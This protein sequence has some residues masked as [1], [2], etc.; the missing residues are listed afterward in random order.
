MRVA[1]VGAGI[2]GLTCALRL[3]QQGHRV[4]VFESEPEV[5]GRMGTTRVEGFCV[6]TGANLLL[7]N[8]ARLHA[9][10]DELG[11]A[12]QLFDF[13]SG[14]G[15]ILRDHELT[16]FTPAS[17]FDVLRYRGVSF[18]SRLRLLRYFIR[19]FQWTSSLEFFDL[20]AG[21][22]PDADRNAY[23]ATV[24]RLGEEVAAYIVDPF[25]RAFHFHGAR[26]MS[27]KYFDALAALFVGADGFTPRGFSGFMAT[28][29]RAIGEQ[30]DVRTAAPVSLVQPGPTGVDVDGERFDAAVL[31]VPAPI[32]LAML[33]PPS[34]AQLAVLSRTTYAP[35][36]SVAFR[37]PRSIAE[38]FEG[39]WIPYSESPLLS[40]CSN[41]TCKGAKTDTECVFNF[42]MH[43]EAASAWL[44]RSDEEVFEAVAAE[45]ARLFPRYRGALRGLHVKRWPLAM[46]IYGPGQVEQ[47]RRFWSRGQGDGRVY[48]CGDYLNHP[49]I[50]GSIRCGEKVAVMLSQVADTGARPPSA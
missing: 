37:C 21:E 23:S 16:S 47:V 24:E 2:S 39:I 9:L 18:A 41:E 38:D 3:Q 14:A 1:V 19:A 34:R 8:F 40:E 45:W 27:M 49:W 26:Q 36:L 50:E 30:L 46:P 6:D 12:E 33:A 25:V 31:A 7:A 13:E 32:A 5:G 20:S 22:D 15:G 10:C 28:L 42:G 17:A 29:P 11:I 44:D 35:T 48:L 4:V 43:A